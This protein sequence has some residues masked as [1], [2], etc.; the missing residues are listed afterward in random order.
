[1][2][3]PTRL[4]ISALVTILTAVLVLAPALFAA[5]KS[6]TKPRRVTA[7]E[8]MAFGVDMAK[9]G[10]WREALFRFQRARQLDPDTPRVLNNMAVAF[11]AVG[12]FDR[13]LEY[14]KLALES[15][16]GNKDLRKNYARF[17]EFYQSFRPAEEGE[18]A[19]QG[20]IEDETENEGGGATET[21]G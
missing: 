21:T 19:V 15:D 8:Q 9:R 20:Q 17:V 2:S 5:K 13:A 14:Y 16:S 11:E 7:E 4:K 12:D 3:R 18:E 1:M 10:L 6:K